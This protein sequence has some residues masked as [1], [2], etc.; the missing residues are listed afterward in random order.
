KGIDGPIRA[1]VHVTVEPL[2]ETRRPRHHRPR[3]ARRSRPRFTRKMLLEPG[4]R[5]S[6]PISA[7][8]P[9][10]ARIPYRVPSHAELPDRLR[11]VLAVVYLVFNEGY[12]ATAG[13]SLVRSE[14]SD[15]A[16]RLGRLLAE[17]MPDEPEVMGLLALMLLTES[18]RAAR[19]AS[20]G[21]LVPLPE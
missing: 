12:V 20:D 5:N 9:S 16:I 4:P 2:T 8:P 10:T 14:L 21:S 17:L 18:R 3:P 13:G 11:P 7:T 1:T 6:P 15:E 19:T